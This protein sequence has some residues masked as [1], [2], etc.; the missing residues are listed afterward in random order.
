M[1]NVAQPQGPPSNIPPIADIH[2][3]PG[4]VQREGAR[5]TLANLEPDQELVDDIPDIP[6]AIQPPVDN[7]VWVPRG[8]QPYQDPDSHHSLGGM[9]V[10]CPKCHALH[11]GAEKLTAST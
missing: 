6:R 10:E 7:N 2:A 3:N 5:E 8:C 4:N 9:N 11:F 1:P